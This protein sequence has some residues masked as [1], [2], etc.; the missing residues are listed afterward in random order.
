MRAGEEAPGVADPSQS[1][2]FAT[3]PNEIIEKN[4]ARPKSARRNLTIVCGGRG[5][6]RE[7]PALSL[8]GWPGPSLQRGAR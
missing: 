7:D 2:R 4:Q 5:D 1:G 6:F 3:V 8:M